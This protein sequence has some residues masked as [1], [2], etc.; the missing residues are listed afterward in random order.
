MMEV[1]TKLLKKGYKVTITHEWENG[2]LVTL[3]RGL[4][5]TKFQFCYDTFNSLNTFPGKKGYYIDCLFEAFL[6]A[7]SN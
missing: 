7:N 5:F 3:E 4:G 6:E 2:F 1:I